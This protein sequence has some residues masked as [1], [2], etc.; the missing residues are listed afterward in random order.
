MIFRIRKNKHR[1]WPPRF[2]LF[3]SKKKMTRRVVFDMSCKYEIEGEDMDDTNKL[4]G[5]GY[6]PGHHRNSVRFGWRYSP[7]FRMIII[8]AYCYINA[9]REIKHICA[10]RIGRPLIFSIEVMPFTYELRVWDIE[11]DVSV[12]A[13]QVQ[14]SNKKKWGFPLGLYFGGNK[15]APHDMTVKI[16]KQ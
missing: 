7:E 10:V 11:D 6:F 13:V 8:T 9:D 2:G 15:T 14:H 5:I 12:G 4:Y 16:T 3:F 1:A